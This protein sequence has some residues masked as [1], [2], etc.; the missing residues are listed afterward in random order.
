[1]Q[2]VGG[3]ARGCGKW[4]EYRMRPGGAQLFGI[5]AS[6]G[7]QRDGAVELVVTKTSEQRQ[8]GW[9]NGDGADDVPRPVQWQTGKQSTSSA[10]PNSAVTPSRWFVFTACGS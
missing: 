10:L 9:Q 2:G 7:R 8:I 3:G 4:L 1:M 5:V 6:V